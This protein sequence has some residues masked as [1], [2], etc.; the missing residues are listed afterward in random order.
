MQHSFTSQ[1]MPSFDNN[2][3][4]QPCVYTIKG[5]EKGFERNG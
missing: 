1:P 5:I 2:Q 4:S 3:N